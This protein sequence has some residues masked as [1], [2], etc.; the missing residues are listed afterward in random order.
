MN[1]LRI[2]IKDVKLV[3]IQAVIAH[4]PESDFVEEMNELWKK[5]YKQINVIPTVAEENLAIGYWH[6]IDKFRRL[7]FAG[8]LVKTLEEFERDNETG[9]CY[10]DLSK[11]EMAIF[12]EKNGEEGSIVSSPNT[13]KKINELDYRENNQFTGYYVVYPLD[14]IKSG[15][16]PADDYHEVWIPIIKK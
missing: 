11:S 13:F 9:L 14:W 3:G 10:W 6:W 8:I 12:K 7:F 16:I 4:K 2:E 1:D 15:K 5:V